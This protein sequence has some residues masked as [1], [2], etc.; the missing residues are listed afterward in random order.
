[1]NPVPEIDRY[2]NPPEKRNKKQTPVAKKVPDI[3][4]GYGPGYRPI[5]PDTPVVPAVEVT[6]G[7]DSGV[8]HERPAEFINSKLG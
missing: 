1:M 5:Y 8:D 2:K 3:G 7:P 6:P 4:S